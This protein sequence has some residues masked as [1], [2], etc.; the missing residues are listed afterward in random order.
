MR[1]PMMLSRP[2]FRVSKQGILREKDWSFQLKAEHCL[3]KSEKT[4]SHL[5][6]SDNDGFAKILQHK[7]KCGRCVRESVRALKY[8]ITAFNCADDKSLYVICFQ[9]SQNSLKCLCHKE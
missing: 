5:G 9:F 3:S 2:S 8:L 4:A 7:G 1:A 6:P